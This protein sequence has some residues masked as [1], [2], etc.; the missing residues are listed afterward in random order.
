MLDTMDNIGL[1]FMFNP[2]DSITKYVSSTTPIKFAQ[3]DTETIFKLCNDLRSYKS[4]LK[5]S[6][7]MIRDKGK[8]AEVLV[9]VLTK[10]YGMH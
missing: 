4:L 3:H 7:I 1:P 5:S 6:V 8:R 10:E 2:P 9:R